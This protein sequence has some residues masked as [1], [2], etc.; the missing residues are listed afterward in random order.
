MSTNYFPHYYGA[1]NNPKILMLRGKFGDT[2]YAK[3]F[4]LLEIMAESDSARLERKVFD[5]IAISLAIDSNQLK[6]I[7]DFCIEIGLFEESDEGISARRMMAHK[8]FR[9][10]RAASGRKGALSRWKNGTPNSL[11]NSSANSSATSSAYAIKQ[12]KGIKQTKGGVGGKENTV[13]KE[14]LCSPILQYVYDNIMPRAKNVRNKE[15]Y[16]QKIYSDIVVELTSAA[17]E[18]LK[19]SDD[20]HKSKAFKARH[21]LELGKWKEY[22]D[23]DRLW[24]AIEHSYGLDYLSEI[25]VL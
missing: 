20:R 11:S 25:G 3:Y 2:G 6:E 7:V 18:L 9:D 16:A 19:P 21:D 10:E 13:N 14:S 5:G 8:E 22:P 24:L 23:I 1:R 12:I 17:E 4:M 15:A